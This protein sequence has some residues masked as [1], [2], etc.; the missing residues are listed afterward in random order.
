MWHR[1][2]QEIQQAY[3]M[4]DGKHKL[5]H[6]GLE[7]LLRGITQKASFFTLGTLDFI[8]KAVKNK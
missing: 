8:V 3:R 1:E 6:A 5:G 4:K 7:K 2:L